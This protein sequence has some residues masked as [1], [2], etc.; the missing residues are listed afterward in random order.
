MSKFA[1]CSG[2]ASLLASLAFMQPLLADSSAEIRDVAGCRTISADSERL[3]CYDAVVDGGVFNQQEV[4]KESFGTNKGQ[5]DS[6]IEKLMVTV[7]RVEK[8]SSGIH[9]FYTADEQVWKQANRGNWSLEVPFPAEIKAGMLGSYFL[10]TDGGK[11][12]R[13]KRVR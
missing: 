13:V 1:I 7:V 12:V 8:S 9:Y 11:S 3:L 6:S 10:V 2:F 4:Q 5:S